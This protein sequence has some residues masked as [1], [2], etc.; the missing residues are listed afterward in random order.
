[1]GKIIKLEPPNFMIADRDGVEK[2]ILITDKTDIKRFRDTIKS[3]DLK[4]DD[5]INVIGA[6]NDKAQIE[7]KFIR[8]LPPPP[9]FSTA[10]GTP[11]ATDTKPQ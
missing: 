1:M 7:A 3:V 11:I 10:T 9:D 6:P 2:I 8:V 5:F 4:L